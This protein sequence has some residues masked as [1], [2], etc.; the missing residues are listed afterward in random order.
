MV[1]ADK[2]RKEK[3]LKIMDALDLAVNR[4]ESNYE[5][6]QLKKESMEKELNVEA[7]ME[8]EKE[9]VQPVESEP[10][11]VVRAPTPFLEGAGASI[12]LDIAKKLKVHREKILKKVLPIG[13][14]VE[15]IK[16]ENM[17]R[18]FASRVGLMKI[19][20]ILALGFH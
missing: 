16:E 3:L 20:S 8:E 13:K 5:A 10:E 12:N 14:I 15:S 7:K 11:K 18:A 9:D 6:L 17:M 19:S 4:A 1:A 2:E